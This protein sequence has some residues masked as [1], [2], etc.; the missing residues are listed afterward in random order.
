MYYLLAICLH[1]AIHP[2]LPERVVHV[3]VSA[4]KQAEASSC[5]G[6]SVE[7]AA[8]PANCLLPLQRFVICITEIVMDSVEASQPTQ[9][10]TQPTN[11]QAELNQTV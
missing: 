2:P 8:F 3:A 10:T 11:S 1:L 5:S 6:S 7:E 9:L 4:V